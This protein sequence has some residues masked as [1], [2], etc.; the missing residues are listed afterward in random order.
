MR[1]L[2]QQFLGTNHS[3]SICG[4]NIARSLLEKGHEV[5]LFS[6]NG[7]DHFPEDLKVN[8]IGS[9]DKEKQIILGTLPEKT[10]DCQ[11]S[12]TAFK[13]FPQYLKHG[14]KNRF[15]LW[16]Y[17]FAG[18]NALP[19]GFAKNYKATDLIL[20]PSTFAKQ[21]FLDSGIPDSHMKVVPHGID[22]EQ[23]NAAFPYILQTKKKT[24]ILAVIA[25]IHRRKNLDGMLEMYGKAFSKTDDVCLVLKVQDRPAKNFF[26]LNFKDIFSKFKKQ[27]PNHAEIEIVDQFIPNIYS[28]YKACDIVFSASHCEGFG[29]T[30]LDALALGKINIAPNYGGFTDFLNHDNSLL[31]EGREFFVPPNFLYW[32]QKN[33]TKA[34]MP[35]IESGVDKLRYAVSHK[36]ELLNKFAQNINI[37]RDHYSWQHVTSQIMDLTTDV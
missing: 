22:F 9:F 18:K 35:S 29:I 2:I 3:W 7:T 28:L 11:I 15:G 21:V 17:E 19:D 26:E 14:T 8:L 30:A 10:Y 24:R 23:V 6:T 25:Q 32:S 36:D 5:D 34:F 4:Q 27:F 13:N 1:I 12:Y 33:K 31:I 37:T 16:T 20:P